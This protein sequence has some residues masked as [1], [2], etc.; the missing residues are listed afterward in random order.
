MSGNTKFKPTMFLVYDYDKEEDYI[1]AMSLKGWQLKKG[2]M[3]HHTY[4]RSDQVYRY[5]L[6]FNN[7]AN[8]NPEEGQRYLHIFSEQGWEHINSTF[9]GW[10][11]FRKKYDPGVSEDEY[12]I[13]TDDTSLK[14][15]LGKWIKFARILQVFL[16]LMLI[17]YIPMYMA[18]KSLLGMMDLIIFITGMLLM[19]LAVWHLK[20]KKL[21]ARTKSVPASIAG[22]LLLII[23]FASLILTWFFLFYKP[24]I[25]KTDFSVNS[26]TE[27]HIDTMT[28]DSDGHYGLYLKCKSSGGSAFLR[29]S[30]N[31]KLI[32]RSGGEASSEAWLNLEAGKYRIETIYDPKTYEE[33]YDSTNELTDA[34]DQTDQLE[35]TGSVDVSIR[36]KKSYID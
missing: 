30:K 1:N 23:M 3:F 24:S 14:E 17:I 35:D 36:V 29:I 9:N 4:E 12:D 27:E 31:N 8:I 18:T 26:N 6:D 28:L 32:F 33:I 13:Y 15:M 5:R 34:P 10:H 11:Y 7:K 2:G 20:K 21:S 25:Y 22:Y 19:Q 16:T